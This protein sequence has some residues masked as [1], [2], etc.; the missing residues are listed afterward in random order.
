MPAR[1]RKPETS[2]DQSSQRISSLAS[3]KTQAS[4]E[5]QATSG[6]LPCRS[7]IDHSAMKSST[8]AA[9]MPAL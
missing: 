4:T 6:R 7:R 8:V 9:D 3:L 2:S 1:A 5:S